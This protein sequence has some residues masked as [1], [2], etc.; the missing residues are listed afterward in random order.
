MR[1]IPKSIRQRCVIAGPAGHIYTDEVLELLRHWAGKC[2][3]TLMAQAL[4]CHYPGASLLRIWSL[5]GF[6]GFSINR[7]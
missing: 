2:P 6:G 4:P 5:A 1:Q 7:P 3:V